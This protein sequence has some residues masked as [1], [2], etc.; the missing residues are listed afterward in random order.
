MNLTKGNVAINRYV[1]FT[2]DIHVRVGFYNDNIDIDRTHHGWYC[3][4][5][6]LR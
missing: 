6:Q 3:D 1:L 4:L 5:W 2:D